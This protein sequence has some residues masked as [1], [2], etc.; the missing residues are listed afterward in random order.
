VVPARYVRSFR[1]KLVE[2]QTIILN[3]F[4]VGENDLLSRACSNA[5]KLVWFDG[6]FISNGS[7][8]PIPEIRFFFK[9]FSEILGRNWHPDDIHGTLL[10]TR[11]SYHLFIIIS[12]EVNFFYSILILDVIG[13]VHEVT[14]HQRIDSK[15]PLVMFVLRDIK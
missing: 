6:T 9:D 11:I 8:P 15:L 7:L 14:F 4:K 2:Y 12:I 1:S 5:L 3:N 10:C 13:V